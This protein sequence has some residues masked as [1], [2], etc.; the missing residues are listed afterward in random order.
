MEQLLNKLVNH[1]SLSKEQARGV[2][3][4]ISEGKYNVS[5]IASFL[6]VYRMRPLTLE[7]LEGFR[8]ALLDLC[9]VVDIA[10]Y[11][12]IDLCGTG[13]DGKNTFN[14]STL[15]SFVT[16][17]ADVLVSK[18][19]NYGVSSISGS[20]NVMEYLGVKFSTNPDFLKRCLDQARICLL[21]APLFHPAM[22]NVAPI[23]KELGVKTFFNML[24]PMV[25]PAFPKN[26]LVGVFDLELARM[27]GYIYQKG[28]KN[29]TILHAMDGYDEVSLT[30][31]V[32]V[33][34]NS[35]ETVL[36]PEDF[37]LQK[38]KQSDIYGGESIKKAAEIFMNILNGFGTVAQ[39]NVVCANAGLAIATVQKCTLKQGI[40]QAQESLMSGNAL[41]SLQ[42]LQ[43]LSRN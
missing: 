23:R 18:H 31:S 12:T 36:Q 6:T 24:G 43:S 4:S 27:Y 14:I 34:S 25:N 35:S 26:Q 41:S 21:H 37:G 13:G 32:K 22:K 2:L 19:G 29:Y 17:G 7:E 20:S 5:Q 15:A 33:I 10:H 16:A 1:E 42:K 8:D 9:L 30:G 3:V 40:L 39:N 11:N 28:V 38:T